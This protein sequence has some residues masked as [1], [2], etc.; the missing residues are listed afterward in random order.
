MDMDKI[1]SYAAENMEK[2][3][4]A[5][6]SAP[7]AGDIKK[8][9]LRR[10]EGGRF[11]VERHT[12]NKASSETFEGE[13]FEKCL[14]S[15]INEGFKQTELYFTDAKIT[16]LKNKKGTVTVKKSAV[17]TVMQ[18]VHNRKK[19]YLFCEG[20][21]IPALKD[22]GVFTAENKIAAAKYDKFKQINRFIE[23]VDDALKDRE[24]SL[25]VLDFGCGKSYLTFLLYYYLTV[26][27]CLK[28]HIIGYDLKEDVVESCNRTAKK[29]GY[30]GL[31]FIKA[32]VKK[33]K[34]FSENIDMVVTLHAC[35]TATD[36]A[37]H[38]AAARGAEYIFSVPCCQHEVNEQIKGEGDFGIMLR[39]GLIKERFSALLTDAVR[40]KAL[41]NAGYSVDCL[42]FV[43]FDASPK[44]LMIRAR[45]TGAPR[46][47]NGDMEKLLEKYNVRQTLLELMKAD[48]QTINGR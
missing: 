42:E 11:T 46:E 1:M 12:E 37:L 44:N 20:E 14:F 48:G 15:Q 7:F 45:K 9:V 25:T 4:K 27:K 22:L 32:D 13:N 26:K 40:V 23:I 39:H 29:Y 8:M 47:D 41:E 16:I 6:S 5:V 31:E 33:D 35:D 36:H 19:K 38:F 18:A 28:T 17:Q 10:I 34:L 3:V 30:D 43:G 21:D 24:G 2:F